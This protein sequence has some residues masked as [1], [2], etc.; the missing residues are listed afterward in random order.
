M[1]YFFLNS[2]FV[3]SEVIKEKLST[4][5]E[6]VQDVIEEAGKSD[7]AKK[8]GRLTEDLSKNVSSSISEKAHE[9]GKT[10]AFQSISQ[11]TKAVKKEIDT[12]SMHGN[13]PK[14]NCS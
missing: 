1:K 8:A 14:F 3:G 2:I 6:K 13:C 9:L 5:K 11:A 7:I 4:I 10:A 12:T